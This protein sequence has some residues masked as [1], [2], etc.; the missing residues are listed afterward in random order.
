M[1][2]LVV[3]LA[4]ACGGAHNGDLFDEGTADGGTARQALEAGA[5]CLPVRVVGCR[6]FDNDRACFHVPAGCDLT[7]PAD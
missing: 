4:M 3:L 7:R 6:S 1:T 5:D 2:R